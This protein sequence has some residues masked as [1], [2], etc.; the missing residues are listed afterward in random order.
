MQ[1]SQQT[2]LFERNLIDR[3]TLLGMEIYSLTHANIV[4]MDK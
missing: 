1:K 3:S 2:F 4:G